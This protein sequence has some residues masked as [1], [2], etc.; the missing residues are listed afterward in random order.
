[1][2]GYTQ[3]DKQRRR[4][5]APISN[6]G[7]QAAMSILSHVYF[8]PILGRLIRARV[9]DLLDGEGVHS[10]KLADQAGLHPL[11]T[12]RALRALTAF[13]VFREVAPCMFVNSAASSLFRDAPGG[14]RNYALFATSEQQFM[15]SSAALGHSLA[16]GQAAHDH[17]LGQ[18]V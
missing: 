10:T 4:V 15:K 12:V 7:L 17:A 18:K 11:A 16:T 8:A 13:G 2:L 9:L 1:M 3:A 5:T 14:I 6:S